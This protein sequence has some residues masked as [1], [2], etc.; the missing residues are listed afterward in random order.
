MTKL[1]ASFYIYLLAVIATTYILTWYILT[2]SPNRCQMT[3][4]MEP[5]KFIPIE[6]DRDT[7]H[8]GHLTYPDVARNGDAQ[9]HTAELKYKLYMYSE[10]GFPMAGDIRR[11]LRDS[12][13]V[14]FVPGNAGSYQQVRSL[15]STCIRRQLQSLDAFKFIFYT[16]DFGGQ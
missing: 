15:A 14:L 2:P 8:D 9:Q 11:D 5:P 3:F 1:G 13:P 4:M 12:M 10:F 16:I 7:N 6:I